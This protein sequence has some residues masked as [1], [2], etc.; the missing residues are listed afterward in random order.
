VKDLKAS[1]PTCIYSTQDSYWTTQAQH[2]QIILK[3]DAPRSKQQGMSL[4]SHN[5]WPAI[6]VVCLLGQRVRAKIFLK[7]W[8][9][10]CTS[11]ACLWLVLTWRKSKSLMDL[12]W[13]H[14][15]AHSASGKAMSC[16]A[17]VICL[18]ACAYCCEH[19]VAAQMLV[20]HLGAYDL[21]E[22]RIR[23]APPWDLPCW[24]LLPD[25][26]PSCPDIKYVVIHM[27]SM[28]AADWLEPCRGKIQE[29]SSKYR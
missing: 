16:T 10:F 6:M 25:I 1:D 27:T 17:R 28:E 18:S 15:R 13:L 5:L 26:L 4:N 14:W 8:W 2:P 23:L 12:C 22:G 9:A 3:V 19:F 24:P 11:G 29:N 7:R 20:E 21:V